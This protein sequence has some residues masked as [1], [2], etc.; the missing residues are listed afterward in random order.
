MTLRSLAPEPLRVLLLALVRASK[1]MAV[2]MAP[3]QGSAQ[4]AQLCP[5]CAL[6]SALPLGNELLKLVPGN[7]VGLVATRQGACPIKVM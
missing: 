4:G 7:T 1:G 6:G 3:P 2:A 5:R